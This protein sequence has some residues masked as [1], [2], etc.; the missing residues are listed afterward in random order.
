MSAH[1]NRRPLVAS[2]GWQWSRASTPLVAPSG[3]PDAPDPSTPLSDTLEFQQSLPSATSPLLQWPP[4]PDE[5]EVPST[6]VV[7][8]TSQ[9]SPDPSA[10]EL[11]WS[12]DQNELVYPLPSLPTV[13]ISHKVPPA[14][15]S[16]RVEG[17]FFIITYQVPK[18]PLVDSPPAGAP[19]PA[20]TQTPRRPRTFSDR[21]IRARKRNQAR[22]QASR[23]RP[24]NPDYQD[25]V[26][27]I[28]RNPAKWASTTFAKRAFFTI[29]R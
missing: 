19:T 10:L 1:D 7:Q 20:E 25:R 13:P 17:N 2:L 5:P 24:H 9:W 26:N 27:H 23:K 14:V 29:F 8:R 6:P 28:R 12:P 21:I 18:T 16:S 3:F 15:E 4:G 22:L 11:Q